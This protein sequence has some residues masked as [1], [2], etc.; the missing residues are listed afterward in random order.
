MVAYAHSVQ[1]A[2]RNPRAGDRPLIL[3]AIGRS[4]GNYPSDPVLSNED[5][6]NL[7]QANDASGFLEKYRVLFVVDADK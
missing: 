6:T 4:R 7:L 1:E 2:C 3:R 5:A